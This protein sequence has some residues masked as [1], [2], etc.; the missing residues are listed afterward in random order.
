MGIRPT[1]RWEAYDASDR[2]TFHSALCRLL[3]TE[4][5]QSAYPSLVARASAA[6]ART[7]VCC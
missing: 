5:P 6:C 7:A 3:H 2:K 4:W 1:K